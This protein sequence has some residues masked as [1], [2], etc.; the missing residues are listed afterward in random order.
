MNGLI[1]TVVLACF[2]IG[3]APSKPSVPDPGV[4][5]DELEQYVESI[6]ATGDPPGISVV[7]VRGTGP[8]YEKGFGWADGPK[9]RSATP[10][11][12]YQWWSITKIVTSVAVLQLA[13]ADKLDLDAPVARYLPFFEPKNAEKHPPVT[14][15]QLLSHSGCLNDVGFAIVG[16][17]H[18]EATERPRQ[19]EF[20][21]EKLRKHGKLVCEPGSEGRYTNLDYIVL[22][23]L[24]EKLSG[25]SYEGYVRE[26]IFR[27]LRMNH[28]NFVY[29]M[30]MAEHEA[31]GSHPKNLMSWAAFKFF[32]PEKRAVRELVDDRYWFEHVYSDQKGSTGAIGSASDMGRFAR[33]LLRGGELDGATILSPQ[34]VALM[35][36]PVVDVDEG[37]SESDMKFGLGWFIGGDDDGRVVLSHGGGGMAFRTMLQLY[38]EDDLAVMVLGN[39]TY[40]DGDGGRRIADATADAVLD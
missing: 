7:A 38:P 33:A 6:V 15:R 21:E 2:A 29:T 13:E 3:C 17:L 27:P 39:S 5:L 31:A 26:H 28:T 30:A 35:A 40:L 20:A 12:V 14:V 4:T 19:L 1:A 9:R 22:A 11:T 23:A 16:W 25:R 8:V 34:S 32:V 18:F 10:D 24:I 36:R 37:A